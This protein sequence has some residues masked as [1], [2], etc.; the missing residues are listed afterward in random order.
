MVSEIV[1]N[2]RF[3]VVGAAGSIGQAVTAEIFKR[4]PL[5]LHAV[6]ISEN[7]VE[8]VRTLRSTVGYGSGDFRTYAIDVDS[9]EFIS[10][11]MINTPMIIFNLS[12]LVARLIPYTLMRLIRVNINNSPIEN[13]I[14]A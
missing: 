6:D 5:I 8:L 10:R 4:N 1:R 9:P 11:V 14:T 13:S 2:S 3:L 7:M 12:A